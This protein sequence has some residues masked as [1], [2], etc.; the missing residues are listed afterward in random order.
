[1]FRFSKYVDFFYPF[2]YC[3]PWG[4][5]FHFDVTTYM[6]LIVVGLAYVCLLYSIDK[7]CKLE[8]ARLS[9]SGASTVGVT[10][11]RVRHPQKS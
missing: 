5:V 1:M 10:G 11:V 3:S 2:S 6:Y 4:I 8:V 9:T 7:S